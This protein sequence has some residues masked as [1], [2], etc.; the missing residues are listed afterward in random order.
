MQCD[1]INS[2]SHLTYPMQIA[3]H[4]TSSYHVL[5]STLFLLYQQIVICTAVIEIQQVVTD[6]RNAQTFFHVIVE[7]TQ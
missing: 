1:R 6:T 4:T 7:R 5:Q 3:F 2:P